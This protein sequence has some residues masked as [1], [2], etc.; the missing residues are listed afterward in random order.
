METQYN[1]KRTKS[2]DLD[3]FEIEKIMV[4]QKNEMEGRL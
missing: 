1:K 3:Q 2:L 4:E